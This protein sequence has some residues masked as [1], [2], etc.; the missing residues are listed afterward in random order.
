MRIWQLPINF[1]ITRY[2]KFDLSA[3]ASP[4]SPTLSTMFTDLVS[5]RV[6]VLDRTA[7]FCKETK[8]VTLRAEKVEKHGTPQL[9]AVRTADRVVGRLAFCCDCTVM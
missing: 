7:L 5:T 8:L 6:A 1:K 9:A 4:S 3:K 2:Y